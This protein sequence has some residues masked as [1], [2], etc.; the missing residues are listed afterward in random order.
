PATGYLGD[1]F[2]GAGPLHDRNGN[3]FLWSSTE[4]D[5]NKEWMEIVHSSAVIP[6]Y[7]SKGIGAMVRLFADE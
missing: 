6:S 3:T 5:A 1:T 7:K 2:Q 4:R